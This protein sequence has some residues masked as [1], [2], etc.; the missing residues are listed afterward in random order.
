MKERPDPDAPRPAEEPD[1]ALD[2]S[3]LDAEA[4]EGLAIVEAALSSDP[5][6][7]GLSS[8]PSLLERGVLPVEFD[9]LRLERL[10]GRG[11]MG[12]VYLGRQ[13][14]LDRDV[15]VKVAVA[16][17]SEEIPSAD[18]FAREGRLLAALDHPG[19]VRVH[20]VGLV[21]GRRYLVMERVQ[22]RTLEE[23]GL[24]S[25]ST[26]A[27]LELAEALSEALAAAHARGVVHR[28]LKPANVILAEEGG[29][30][31]PRLLD[32]G[33][34]G[35][36]FDPPEVPGLGTQRYM[37]PEQ[38]DGR[39]V[40]PAADIYALGVLLREALDGRGDLPG[41]LPA[42]LVAMTADD[43][44][45]RPADGAALLARLRPFLPR[46]RGARPARRR[47]MLIA[48]ALVLLTLVAMRRG[49]FFRTEAEPGAAPPTSEQRL[50]TRLEALRE[51]RLDAR[52]DG[53]RDARLQPRL[54]PRLPGRVGGQ[55]A[56]RP[57]G[58]DGRPLPWRALLPPK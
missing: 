6:A 23:I 1:A 16:P 34:A 24:A 12:E 30:S 45:L 31:R 46:A 55:P 52:V 33:V 43:A 42:L 8:G 49:G 28:D 36:A 27:L 21:A 5:A 44:A 15:A 3:G 7:Y 19:I 35:R 10:L 20:G 37:A 13:L 26:P 4:L 54:E 50:P 25:L 51:G 17:A 9:G 29:R 41:D 22:G 14:G 38:R 57:R 53:R 11:G 18:L 56:L 2:A 48:A 58:P 32:F 39:P 47:T 40:G